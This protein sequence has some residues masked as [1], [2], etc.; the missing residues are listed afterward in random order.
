MEKFNELYPLE[1]ITTE[2]LLCAEA[3][4]FLKCLA[5]MQP[6]CEPTCDEAIE[7][8]LSN[9]FIVSILRDIEKE[10]LKDAKIKSIFKKL[11]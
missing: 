10:G 11:P 2:P 8:L 9:M 5:Q 6:V 3:I 7:E 1:K 4:G